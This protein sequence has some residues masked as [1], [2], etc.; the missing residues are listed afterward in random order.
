[1]PSV[2]IPFSNDQFAWAHRANDL[3]VGSKPIYGRDLTAGRL[4]VAIEFALSDNIVLNSKT[5]AQNI[6]MENGARDCAQV[7][8]SCLER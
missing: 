8:V 7:I 1:M 6:A 4:A 5:L 2:I 3:G